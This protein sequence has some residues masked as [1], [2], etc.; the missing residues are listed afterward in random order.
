MANPPWGHV[1]IE[2]EVTPHDMGAN[3]H[4]WFKGTMPAAD[5]ARQLRTL[6][7]RIEA[8]WSAPQCPW[9]SEHGVSKCE[10]SHHVRIR[11]KKSSGGRTA[12]DSSGWPCSSRACGVSYCL[13]IGGAIVDEPRP[14]HRDV[15]WTPDELSADNVDVW[16][17][18]LE[19]GKAYEIIG[20]LGLTHVR[21]P[22]I[23]HRGHTDADM[24][25]PLYIRQR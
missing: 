19:P 13:V 8:D 4:D 2:V 1:D 15:M 6:A 24:T 17:P 14:V 23:P 11:P 21:C 10:G 7:D 18:V 5:A 9:P 25:C 16:G 20:T 12:G 3:G 22:G